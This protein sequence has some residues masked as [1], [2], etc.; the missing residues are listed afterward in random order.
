MI[1][2]VNKPSDIDVIVA[3][4]IVRLCKNSTSLSLSQINGSMLSIS[5]RSLRDTLPNSGTV[6]G[7]LTPRLAYG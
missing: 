5:S 2:K 6:V 1:S 7:L 3:V 4:Y